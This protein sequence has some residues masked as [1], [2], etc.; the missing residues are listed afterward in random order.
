MARKDGRLVNWWRYFL[1]FMGV[2]FNKVKAVHELSKADEAYLDETERALRACAADPAVRELLARA[3]ARPDPH[4]NA[5]V[6]KGLKGSDS[7]LREFQQ[8]AFVEAV[9]RHLPAEI[10]NAYLSSAAGGKVAFLQK[11]SLWSHGDKNAHRFP[12]TGQSYRETI[13]F[14][15]FD[16]DSQV[17]AV[18]LGV[19]V[20]LNGRAAG[21]LIVELPYPFPVAAKQGASA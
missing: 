10:T 11:P 20:E 21:S 6:W 4:V 8:P 3:A 1:I 14:V 16:P 5:E 13:L 2:S 9:R 15:P 17:R 7:F 19:P 12:L 18:E